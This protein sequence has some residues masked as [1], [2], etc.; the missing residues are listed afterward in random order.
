VDDGNSNGNGGSDGTNLVECFR[1]G[2]RHG[3]YP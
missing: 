3:R 2:A 1:L